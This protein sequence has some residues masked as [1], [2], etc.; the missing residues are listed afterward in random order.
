[1]WVLCVCVHTCAS[2][3][4]SVCVASPSPP[5]ACA[6]SDIR[7]LFGAHLLL[8]VLSLSPSI[9]PSLPFTRGVLLDY[10]C[11]FL[12]SLSLSLSLT[13]TLSLSLSLSHTHTHTHSLPPSR[14][15][16]VPA[17][18]TPTPMLIAVWGE[19]ARAQR[20]CSIQWTNRI[21]ET[22]GNVP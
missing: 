13:H 22:E 19:A 11:F 9:P 2:V 7:D 8:R 14:S 15:F 6:L 10:E 5:R 1:M 3:C 4:I 17:A 21:L 18:L 12:L 16:S 20:A